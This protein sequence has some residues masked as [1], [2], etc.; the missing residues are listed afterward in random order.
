MPR[1]GS[2]AVKRIEQAEGFPPLEPLYVF[3]FSI[4]SKNS[5]INKPEIALE[6]TVARIRIATAFIT[7]GESPLPYAKVWQITRPDL[8]DL[9]STQATEE[10]LGAFV[11]QKML[12]TLGKNAHI[13]YEPSQENLK[14]W[15]EDSSLFVKEKRFE[16]KACNL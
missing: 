2:I 13:D 11:Y 14:I 8:Q 6:H 9:I 1:C 16:E 15:V 3:A 7:S 5:P 4:R 10:L 12:H